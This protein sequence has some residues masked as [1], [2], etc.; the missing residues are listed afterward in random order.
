MPVRDGASDL[1]LALAALIPQVDSVGGEV[2]VVDDASQDDSPAVAEAAGAR[3]VRLTDRNGPYVAR[4]AGWRASDAPVLVFTDVRNRAQPDW[5]PRLLA[6]LEDP[7][8][9]IA[10]GTVLMA[11]GRRVAER[12]ARKV[13]LL[14]VEARSQSDWLPYVPTASMAVRRAVLERLDGF[15]AVR[16]AGDVDLCWRAQVAALGSVAIAPDSVM[17]CEPRA[18]A[19]EVLRQWTRYGYSNYDVRVRFGADGCPPPNPRSRRAG[20][21]GAVRAIGGALL[22]RRDVAVELLDQARIAA[23]DRAHRRA[24]RRGST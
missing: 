21:A 3:V 6:P 2:I 5:L 9:A 22:H 12:W 14:E 1:A 10:G 19:T 13:Q 17:V 24:A 4:N 23:Y 15:R 11:G 20:A 7:S 16:S 8:V 18:S